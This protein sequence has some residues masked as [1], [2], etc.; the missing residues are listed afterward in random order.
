MNNDKNNKESAAG[1]SEQ[2][3][4]DYESEYDLS[5][6]LK[7][8]D[9]LEKLEE[10]VNE[11]EGEMLSLEESVEKFTI[12]MKLIQHCQQELN[13][14]EGKVE[15]VLEEHGELKEIIPYDGL[16]EDDEE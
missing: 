1:I 14:A 2:L 3:S 6:D 10:I 4:I 12:G 9:A 8:E 7:F 11:L 15:Q 13:K 5:E 16:V